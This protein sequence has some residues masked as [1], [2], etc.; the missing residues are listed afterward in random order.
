MK[1][2]V[3]KKIYQQIKTDRSAKLLEEFEDMLSDEDMITAMGELTRLLKGVPSITI[4][5]PL[6]RPPGNPRVHM[7]SAECEILAKKN[8]ILENL[9]TEAEARNKDLKNQI[10]AKRTLI[11]ALIKDMERWCNI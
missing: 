2:S 7:Y 11:V 4:D 6:W 10:I 9:V 8:Q 5:K 1:K 3:A